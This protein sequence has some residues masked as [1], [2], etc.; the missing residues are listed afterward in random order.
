MG[1]PSKKIAIIGAG[2]AGL[3]SAVRLASRGHDVTVFESNDY[4]GGKLSELTVGDFRFDA[5]PSLF[6]MPQYIDDLF[7]LTNK[8]PED[9]FQ[10]EK[11]PVVCKYFWEDGTT[12]DGYGDLKKFSEEVESKL[13]I[14]KNNVI[15][16]FKKA[17]KKYQLTGT[18]F[19]EHSL[20]R[21][22]T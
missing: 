18:T 16:F 17:E 20:H 14:P 7:K 6:T 19:L 8:T 21:S 5:G 15:N 10:Y 4:P 13:S 2:I 9:F 22:D 12:L 3:A 11:L 1:I